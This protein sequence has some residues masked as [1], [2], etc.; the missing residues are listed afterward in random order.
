MNILFATAMVCI[1]LTN[2][3]QAESKIQESKME[4]LPVNGTSDIM[5]KLEVSGSG[6]RNEKCRYL[7]ES[8]LIFYEGN[9]LR[10]TIK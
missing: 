1:L 8:V 2:G 5:P 3:V 10:R 6:S 4:G 7:K 9:N